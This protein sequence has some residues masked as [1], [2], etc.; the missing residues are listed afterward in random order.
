VEYLPLRSPLDKVLVTLKF[1][2]DGF[3]NGC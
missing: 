3:Q 2:R 1:D